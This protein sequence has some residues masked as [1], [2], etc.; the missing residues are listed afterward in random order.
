MDAPEEDSIFEV[1]R[2]PQSQ[3]LL[4]ERKMNGDY[5]QYRRNSANNIRL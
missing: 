4:E 5:A 3:Q 1:L 2:E